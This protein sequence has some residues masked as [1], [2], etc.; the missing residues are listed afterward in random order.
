MFNSVETARLVFAICRPTSPLV[1]ITVYSRP[2]ALVLLIYKKNFGY[3]CN[4]QSIILGLPE[5]DR[6][7]KKGKKKNN[8][9]KTLNLPIFT[10]ANGKVIYIRFMKIPRMIR[11]TVISE[12]SL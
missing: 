2:M 6:G 9:K 10:E 12:A 4:K 11:H 1:P 5:P 7:G 3:Q 8:S